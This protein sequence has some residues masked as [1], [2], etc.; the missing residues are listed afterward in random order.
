MVPE[1]PALEVRQEVPFIEK[2]VALTVPAKVLVAVPLTT[3][4]GLF[5]FILLGVM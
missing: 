3:I 1:L 4:H 5:P 2:Q